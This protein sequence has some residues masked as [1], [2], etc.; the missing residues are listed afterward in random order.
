MKFLF[1]FILY[2][3]LLASSLI[4]FFCFLERILY[5]SGIQE[6]THFIGSFSSTT[7]VG[8]SNRILQQTNRISLPTIQDQQY[9]RKI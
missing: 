8:K 4:K 6:K 3:I 7:N 2:K 1:V 9:G 5:S